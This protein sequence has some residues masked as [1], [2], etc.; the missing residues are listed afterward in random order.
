MDANPDD[1]R[2]AHHATVG[3]ARIRYHDSDLCCDVRRVVGYQARCACGAPFPIRK[4]H[5]AAVADKQR[6]LH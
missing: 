2:T 3:P 1:Y 5:A 4:N 6:H